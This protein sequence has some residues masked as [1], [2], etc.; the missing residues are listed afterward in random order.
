MRS[1]PNTASDGYNEITQGMNSGVDAHQ[2]ERTQFSRM[3]NCTTRANVPTTRPGWAKR[4][5]R[6]M[7]ATGA[8]DTDLK[9]NFESYIFQGASVFE[10]RDQLV[11]SVGGREFSIAIDTWDV[12][13]ITPIGNAA[14]ANLYRAWFCEAEDF[15]IRQDGQTAPWFYD[16]AVTRVSDAAGVNGVRE[17]S[18]GKAMVYSQ[19]RIVVA[20]AD[21]RSF[22]ITD[23]T[24]SDSGTAIYNYRDAVLRQ[25]ENEVINEGG[26][27]SVPINAGPLRAI[28]PVAQVD[29]ST[30]QGPTQIFT[31]SA[32][33]SL[34]TPT[35]RTTW[36]DLS[37]PIQT[38]SVLQAGAASDRAVV[39]VNGDLWMRS[40]DGI[41]SF[42]VARRDFSSRWVNNPQSREVT[43]ETVGDDLTLL[44]F[45]SGAFY[46]NRLFFTVRP[47]RQFGHGV[48]HAAMIVMDFAPI[49]YLS[50]N[51]L[52]VWQG[53]WTGLEILQ[54]LSGVFGGVDRCFVF[55]LN[56][57]NE[58][59]L[60]EMT[61]DEVYD[62]DGTDNVRIQGSFETGAFEFE[63]AGFDMK[64]LSKAWLW[65]T[66]IRGEVNV[67]TYYRADDDPIWHSWSNW[68]AC[69]TNETCAGAG[70]C[71]TPQ[72]LQPQYR[73]PYLLSTPDSGCNSFSGVPDNI[74]EQFALR[75]E[76]TGHTSFPQ[77]LVTAEKTQQDVV[78]VCPSEATSAACAVID[79]CAPDDFHNY[80]IIP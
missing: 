45:S 17:M 59:E 6:F 24:G 47:Y 25:T 48:C 29:T 13:D 68:T 19:G 40:I 8:V 63:D 46:D 55:A 39:T 73:R 12:Q 27:F 75:A 50:S 53:I 80:R 36:K 9:T 23:I 49:S 33:F 58:I 69:A 42:A 64:K 1:D 14:N 38:Y 20:L 57:D 16:G 66:D 18:V 7:D 56:S 2:L 30:G 70:P 32:I 5:L 76:F 43:K 35:D 28:K 34:N 31:Q 77:Y 26:A 78:A 71:V 72:N 10:R 15:L 21:D 62:F 79:D 54:V 51:P 74:G 41:R 4:T 37:F 61:R 60:W 3:T 67:T 65:M 11:V 52:P 44:E 22:V